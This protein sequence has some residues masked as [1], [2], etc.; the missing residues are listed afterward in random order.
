MP[1]IR[2]AKAS[3]LSQTLLASTGASKSAVP[4]SRGSAGS[5]GCE[6][7]A[8]SRGSEGSGGRGGSGGSKGSGDSGVRCGLTSISLKGGDNAEATRGQRP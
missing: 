2:T 6:G 4:S 1:S 3:A 7:S 8:G 5:R